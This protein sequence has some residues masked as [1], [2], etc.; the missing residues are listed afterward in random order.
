M[1][2]FLWHGH[3]EIA[4]AVSFLCFLFS[5]KGSRR[6]S[7]VASAEFA[8]GH[9]WQDLRCM[10]GKETPWAQKCEPETHVWEACLGLKKNWPRNDSKVAIW[11]SV[12]HSWRLV[13]QP[14]KRGSPALNSRMHYGCCSGCK[15]RPR[16]DASLGNTEKTSPH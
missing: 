5:S 10:S 15:V 4:L 6:S 12:E 1:A 14:S 16:P 8:M 9:D 11:M 13:R 7:S 2:V 3:R